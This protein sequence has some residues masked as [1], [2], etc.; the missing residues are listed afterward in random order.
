MIYSRFN[1]EAFV[2]A[3]CDDSSD[4]VVT[5]DG[6]YQRPY[7]SWDRSCTWNAATQAICANQLCYHAGY[8]QG[9]SYL[10]ATNNMCTNSATSSTVWNWVVD[11]AQMRYA[12]MNNDARVTASCRSAE[13]PECDAHLTPYT[14]KDGDTGYFQILNGVTSKLEGTWNRCA[15]E[16]ANCACF[17]TVRYGAGG[18]FAEQQSTG[19]ILCSHTVFG[20][21][22]DGTKYCDCNTPPT[23][24][25]AANQKISLAI[26]HRGNF[27]VPGGQSLS[28]VHK[29]II[30]TLVTSIGDGAQV[31]V[32]LI[33]V[34]NVDVDGNLNIGSTASASSAHDSTL[35]DSIVAGDIGVKAQI[36][37]NLQDSGNVVMGSAS[38][39][40][41][42]NGNLLSE[43]VTTT[44]KT[45]RVTSD[46]SAK[47]PI[48][49]WLHRCSWNLATQNACANQICKFAGYDGGSFVSSSGNMC[50][51]NLRMGRV[52]NYLQDTGRLVYDE[53]ISEARI[54]ADCDDEVR[55][56]S[57]CIDIH[58]TN[59]VNVVGE[60][61]VVITDAQLED[62]AVD[63]A[64]THSQINVQKR[65]VANVEANSLAILRGEL[66][67]ENIDALSIPYSVLTVDMEDFGCA[68]VR[69]SIDITDGE[70]I[71]EIVDTLDLSDSTI[72]ISGSGVANV[73]CDT[74][75]IHEGELLDEIVDIGRDSSNSNIKITMTNTGNAKVNNRATIT[76]GELM[77]EVV[78]NA[79][80]MTSTTISVW[81]QDSGNME[82]GGG[83]TIEDGELIDEI[84]DVGNDLSGGSI[85]IDLAHVAN[86]EASE[87]TVTEGEL[88]DEIVDIGR[89]A[90]T[91]R[92]TIT[93]EDTANARTTAATTITQGELVDEVVDVARSLSGT[94]VSITATRMGNHIASGQ[95]SSRLTLK[96]AQ[97]VD[98][99]LDVGSAMSSSRVT[100]AATVVGNA[101][102][103]TAG[104]NSIKMTSSSLM[105]SVVDFGSISGTTA[106]FTLTDSANA[107]VMN[108]N[109]D[110]DSARTITSDGSKA[111]PTCSWYRSCSWTT[112][113]QQD[114]AEALCEASGYDDGT[115]VSASNNMCTSSVYSG[116]HWVYLW[117]TGELGYYGLRN[118]ALITAKC[119]DESTFLKPTSSSVAQTITR[120][121]ARQDKCSTLISDAGPNKLAG[122]P[123]A[124][125]PVTHFGN[126]SPNSPVEQP[127]RTETGS[128]EPH[129]LERHTERYRGDNRH[130]ADVEMK[131]VEAN[132]NTT[133]NL[134][135]NNL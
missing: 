85:T 55:T 35:I 33:N 109:L 80:D 37:V 28:I 48:C 72:T 56:E 126:N 54:T 115:F 116:S 75:N 58:S 31:R 1:L 41:I 63:L 110:M 105:D 106:S 95:S 9:G 46:G 78:D 96:E 26:C 128:V 61:R 86:L 19:S 65:N 16:G 91:T 127:L 82:A 44:K 97:L 2:T 111:R 3:E 132:A 59:T 66:S 121:G 74:L 120:S 34:A 81:L 17:G 90:T 10:T 52:W 68:T 118:E 108:S 51:T 92:I 50:T 99:I 134:P 93:V 69:T 20:N 27:A 24:K 100:I 89:D 14:C 117:D 18:T 6:S 32:D 47:L 94:N 7:C 62:E 12:A 22:V 64:F 8:D 23:V 5:S 135:S 123:M 98:E 39:L 42:M 76:G 40:T 53:M 104:T 131:D 107:H 114:C 30:P 112:S 125:A 71:D 25:V 102:C 29:A 129:L 130:P 4:V 84:I 67:D 21:P 36:Y 38:T 87:L 101:N 124:D 45:V 70:L 15:S 11:T 57:V 77:D 83:V 79:A 103:Q 113:S 73:V 122:G 119:G 133:S 13:F 49:S 43:A 60:G 88:L